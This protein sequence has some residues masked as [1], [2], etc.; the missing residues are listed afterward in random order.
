METRNEPRVRGFKEEGSGSGESSFG[1]TKECR[2]GICDV[3][4]TIRS[5]ILL[6][7]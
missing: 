3:G 1:G 5:D 7:L 4:A 2:C 6:L